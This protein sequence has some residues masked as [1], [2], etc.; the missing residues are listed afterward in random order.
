MNA[1]HFLYQLSG[2]KWY[3]DFFFTLYYECTAHFMQSTKIQ[4][5]QFNSKF[6]IC[7][8]AILLLFQSMY[9]TIELNEK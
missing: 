9:S 3:T 1:R 2:Q 7:L 4:S 8:Q 5:K 6:I